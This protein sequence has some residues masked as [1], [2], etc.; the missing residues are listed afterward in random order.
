M[1]V[2]VGR[3]HVGDLNI[4]TPHSGHPNQSPQT[5]LPIGRDW[6]SSNGRD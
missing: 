3:Y 6:L 5:R 4:G 2:N 1:L